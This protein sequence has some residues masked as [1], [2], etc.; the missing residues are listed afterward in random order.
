MP[1][2]NRN[3]LPKADIVKRTD[4]LKFSTGDDVDRAD[5]SHARAMVEWC[6]ECVENIPAIIQVFDE[7]FEEA[8]RR[9]ERAGARTVTTGADVG[10]RLALLRRAHRN[11]RQVLQKVQNSHRAV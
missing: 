11:R 5:L 8:D 1:L 6:P 3:R 9:A 2:F 10:P 7:A 4:L